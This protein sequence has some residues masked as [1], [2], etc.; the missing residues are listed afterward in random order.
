MQGEMCSLEGNDGDKTVVLFS[1]CVCYCLFGSQ[2]RCTIVLP[3][4]GKQSIGLPLPGGQLAMIEGNRMI[5]K[6]AYR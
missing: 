4:L 2:N 6:R 5:H 1:Y 3:P